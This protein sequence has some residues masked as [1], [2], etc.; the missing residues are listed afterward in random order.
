LIRFLGGVLQNGTLTA[1]GSDFDGQSG[2][3]NAVLGGSQG[4]V[5]SGS[6]T[7]RLSGLKFSQAPPDLANLRLA[8]WR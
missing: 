6:G 7:L 4:L 1:V 2:V 8:K 3:V 5:K